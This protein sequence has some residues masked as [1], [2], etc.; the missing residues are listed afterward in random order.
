MAIHIPTREERMA[1]RARDYWDAIDAR[2]SSRL[3][4]REKVYLEN[5]DRVRAAEALGL[6]VYTLRRW[7]CLGR[8][9]KPFKRGGFRQSRVFFRREEIDAFL[10]D[11]AAYEVAKRH[12]RGHA[13]PAVETE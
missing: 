13:D 11:P 5:L 12:G 7:I 10:R 9:P 3:A 2:I 6:S 8:G 4:A 1:K